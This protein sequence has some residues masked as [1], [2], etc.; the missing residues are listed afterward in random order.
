MITPFVRKKRRFV[1]T[2][3]T[4]LAGLRNHV[5]VAVVRKNVR[6]RQVK[7]LGEDDPVITPG[8]A[9]AACCER[10]FTFAAIAVDY[11]KEHEPDSAAAYHERIGHQHCRN[12]SNGRA[13]QYG[14]VRVGMG[15][16]M[17][18]R[19]G[20]INADRPVPGPSAGATRL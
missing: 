2:H 17:K 20:A 6:I 10:D 14:I 16:E 3:A 8:N 7:R 12:V 5:V 11:L 4:C 9:V 19:P 1:Q 18:W 15:K 13:C